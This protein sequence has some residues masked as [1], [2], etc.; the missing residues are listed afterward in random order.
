MF[1]QPRERLQNPCLQKTYLPLL[2]LSCISDT[3][4]WRIQEAQ[5]SPRGYDCCEALRTS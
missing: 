2:L 3:R 1:P 5:F 4:W